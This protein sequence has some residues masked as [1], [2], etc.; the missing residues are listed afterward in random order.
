ME[1]EKITIRPMLTE[2]R[3]ESLAADLESYRRK[4]LELGASAVEIIPSSYVSVDERV[5]MRCLVPRCPRAG[6]TPN[7][8]PNAPQPDF[9]RKALSKYSWAIL[10]KVNVEPIVDYVPRRGGGTEKERKTLSYHK[11]IGEIVYQIERTAYAD[12]YYLA[13][14]FG[15][16]SCKDYL[17]GGVI[18]Q[19]LD[20][21]RCRFPLRAR[22]AM[23]AVGIDVFDVIKKVGWQAYPLTDELDLVPHAVS[24]GIVFIH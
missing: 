12:G 18:C 13:M 17:C 7:C 15:G 22:P 16:G 1:A 5:W 6:E 23:E 14:G 20:S 11:Q 4:A 10:F 2:V 21:G 24:V 3:K 8:P 19:F 9:V